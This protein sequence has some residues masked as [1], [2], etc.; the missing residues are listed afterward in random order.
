MALRRT[1]KQK[2][3]SVKDRKR[4]RYTNGSVARLEH[5]KVSSITLDGKKVTGV[6]PIILFL[7]QFFFLPSQEVPAGRWWKDEPDSISTDQ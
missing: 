5:V 2:D 6:D 4:I 3:V 7:P 1:L